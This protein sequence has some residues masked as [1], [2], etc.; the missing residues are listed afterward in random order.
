MNEFDINNVV[1]E[2]EDGNA[3]D[4]ELL[5]E[6]E[7]EETN[8]TFYFYTP[9]DD[10]EGNLFVFY[11]LEGTPEDDMREVVTDE[12]IDLVNKVIDEINAMDFGDDDE[13]ADA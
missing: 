9:V 13:T 10:E 1:I 4:C 12:D 5:L 3:L 8:R 6:F 11:H 2:D 7:E